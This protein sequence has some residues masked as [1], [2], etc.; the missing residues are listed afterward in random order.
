MRYLS[1]QEVVRDFIFVE[2]FILLKGNISN[3]H[4]PYF[5]NINLHIVHKMSKY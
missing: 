5:R 3:S 1:L 4:I 2:K